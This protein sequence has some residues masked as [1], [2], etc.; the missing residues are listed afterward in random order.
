[1]KDLRANDD[2]KT[3]GVSITRRIRVYRT[4]YEVPRKG[5]KKKRVDDPEQKITTKTGSEYEDIDKEQL[6]LPLQ[7]GEEL[8]KFLE[9]NES[10]LLEMNTEDDKLYSERLGQVYDLIFDF[11]RKDE[12][13]KIDWSSRPFHWEPAEDKFKH[14][15]KWFCERNE[16]NRGVVFLP[17]HQLYWVGC[18]E[19]YCEKQ[20]RNDEFAHLIEAITWVEQELTKQKE[21][22]DQEEPIEEASDVDV[23]KSQLLELQE[24]F[25]RSPYWVNP[26][27]LEPERITYRVFIELD[28]MPVKYETWEGVFGDVHKYAKQFLSPAQLFKAINLSLDNFQYDEPLSPNHSWVRIKSLVKYYDQS[29]VINQAQ[30]AW[31]E[32]SISGQFKSGKIRRARYGYQEVETGYCNFLGEC[33]DPE[34]PY[35]QPGSR[36][37]FMKKWA[38]RESIIQS[39]DVPDFRIF[40]GLDPT[41]VSDEK[42]LEALHEQRAN[43]LHQ[44][45]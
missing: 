44:P 14:P 2:W 11:V 23:R 18:V 30:K 31:D 43:S 1:M 9:E 36:S 39:L 38:L 37:E 45:A 29:V 16:P 27:S 20:R 41:D 8:K 26:T 17:N 15:H 24:R 25:V 42:L 34:Y 21:V 6:R 10:I 40:L 32:S 19:C 13:Q 22:D 5:R 33:E 4:E 7:A 28:S 3:S 35:S 12:E